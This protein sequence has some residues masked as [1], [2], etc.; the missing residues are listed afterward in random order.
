MLILFP[1][2]DYLVPT[3]CKGS[4]GQCHRAGEREFSSSELLFKTGWEQSCPKGTI[5][6]DFVLWPF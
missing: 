2:K 3:D 4:L 1:F 5:W 6:Q